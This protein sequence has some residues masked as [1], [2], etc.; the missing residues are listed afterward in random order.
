MA[1]SDSEKIVHVDYE[2]HTIVDVNAL[3]RDPKV[4]ETIERVSKSIER[5]RGKPGVTFVKPSRQSD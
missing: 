2:G 4:L 5:M 1:E 3:L